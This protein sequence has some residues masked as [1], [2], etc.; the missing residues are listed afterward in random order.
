ME[1]KLTRQEVKKKLDKKLD[2]RIQRKRDL[3][4]KSEQ[5]QRNK[6]GR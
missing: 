3:R 5:R 2:R 6:G 1:R 4:S